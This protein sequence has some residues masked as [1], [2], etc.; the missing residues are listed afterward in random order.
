M[1]WFYT[2]LIS[3]FWGNFFSNLPFS[4]I[5]SSIFRNPLITFVYAIVSKWYIVTTVTILVV[6]YY[7]FQGLS[8]IGFIDT[9]EKIVFRSYKEIKSVA[10]H[11]TKDLK[12]L[13]L[14]WHC[15]N[16]PPDYQPYRYETMLEHDLNRLL[17]PSKN[18]EEPVQNDPYLQ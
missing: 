9:A 18:R 11:C 6:T 3:V 16:N 2:L 14:F 7:V 17:I 5:L 8:D 12:D 4:N 13:N 15:I 10:Q 1:Y